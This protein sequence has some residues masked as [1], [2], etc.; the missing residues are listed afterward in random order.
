MLEGAVMAAPLWP[1]RGGPACSRFADMC[2][3]MNFLDTLDKYVAIRPS[4]GRRPLHPVVR[5]ERARKRREVEA[6]NVAVLVEMLHTSAGPMVAAEII[7]YI[8]N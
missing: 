2:L 6:Q 7:K 5:E 1:A 8:N 4:A 3:R